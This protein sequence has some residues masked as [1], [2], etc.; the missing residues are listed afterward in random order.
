MKDPDYLAAMK[1]AKLD[2]IGTMNGQELTAL[3]SDINQ[4]P[5]EVV[6]RIKRIL[7]PLRSK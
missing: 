2:V 5:P 1:E 4:T 7:A 3:I 6:A